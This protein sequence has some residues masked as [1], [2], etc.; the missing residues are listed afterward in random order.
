M[1]QRTRSGGPKAREENASGVELEVAAR[2][3]GVDLATVR[4]RLSMSPTE[5]LA[6]NTRGWRLVQIFR[7]AGSKERDRAG[8]ES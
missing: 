1:V 2:E 8:T 4:E 3:A 5:R 7:R 6:A